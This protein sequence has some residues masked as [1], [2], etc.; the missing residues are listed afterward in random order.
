MWSV[1]QKI[2][3]N[4]PIMAKIWT[5]N[6]HFGPFM[7]NWGHQKAYH[8]QC[9]VAYGFWSAF[10]SI[11]RPGS[12]KTLHI[13]YSMTS[14]FKDPGPLGTLKK[15][16]KKMQGGSTLFGN[17]L[18]IHPIWIWAIICLLFPPPHE[19]HHFGK[20]ILQMSI[21]FTSPNSRR[22]HYYNSWL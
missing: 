18:K 10:E 19:Q 4:R 20:M 7:A 2:Y 6:G 11:W 13:I 16:S 1:E 5:N 9:Q 17:L 22:A 15:L 3:R 21:L 8:H 14:P 12:T